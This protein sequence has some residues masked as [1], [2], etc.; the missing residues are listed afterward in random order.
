MQGCAREMEHGRPSLL[1]PKLLCRTKFKT[2]LWFKRRSSPCFCGTVIL[3]FAEVRRMNWAW[4]LFVY[5][6]AIA[7]HDHFNVEMTSCFSVVRNKQHNWGKTIRSYKIYGNRLLISPFSNTQSC[8]VS[9]LKLVTTAALITTHKVRHET[10]VYSSCLAQ[11]GLFFLPEK[12]AVKEVDFFSH[13]FAIWKFSKWT[14]R[15]S[16]RL[17]KV[18]NRVYNQKALRQNCFQILLHFN[19]WVCEQ[20]SGHSNEYI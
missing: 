14:L 8:K 1:E 9:C 20:I 6:K 5:V 17:F 7:I 13:H 15:G 4:M 3:E 10:R 11:F 12:Y 16:R 18:K 19:F 2:R